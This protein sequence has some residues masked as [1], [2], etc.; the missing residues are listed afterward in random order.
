M[1]KQSVE[2]IT[3]KLINYLDINEV[4]V[5]S[6]GHSYKKGITERKYYF[7]KHYERDIE[8]YL[9]TKFHLQGEEEETKKFF[10]YLLEN[11]TGNESIIVEFFKNKSPATK[12]KVSKDGEI[13]VESSINEYYSYQKYITTLL[14]EDKYQNMLF[15]YIGNLKFLA[16]EPE[17][18]FDLIK[19]FFD[20]EKKISLIE[21]Y[22][23]SKLMTKPEFERKMYDLLEEVGVTQEYSQCFPNLKSGKRDFSLDAFEHKVTNAYTISFDKDTLVTQ[24]EVDKSMDAVFSNIDKIANLA[25]MPELEIENVQ[26]YDTKNK[27]KKNIIFLGENLNIDYLK[28]AVSE[29]MRIVLKT[30]EADLPMNKFVRANLDFDKDDGTWNKPYKEAFEDFKEKMSKIYLKDKIEKKLVKEETIKPKTLKI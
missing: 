15:D 17:I 5:D 23:N 19:N 30:K 25:K 8:E 7:K 27:S 24:I 6:V 29:Y 10:N 22:V 2:F 13:K 18:A 11:K 9:D 4:T 3:E 1:K 26:V 14:R 21:M 28:L 20:Q 12:T 16:S